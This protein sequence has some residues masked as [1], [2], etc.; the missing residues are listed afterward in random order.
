MT[1]TND[2]QARDARCG[3][4]AL[5]LTT[6]GEPLDVAACSCFNC[7][8][9]SGSAFSYWA[10]YPETA[11]SMT[12]PHSIWRRTVDSGR[13]LE[14]AFCPTCGATVSVR[15]EAWPGAVGVSVG[16]FAEPD[17]APPETLYWSSRRHH[18]LRFPDGVKVFETQA[19]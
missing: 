8:R 6:K 4:G 17:F 9:E 7:Q 15:M 2:P 16:C 11:V 13:W 12:G 3:C 14:S 19:D 18:W 10:V 1:E 5:R